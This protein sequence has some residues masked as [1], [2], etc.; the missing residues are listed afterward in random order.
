MAD[1]TQVDPGPAHAEEDHRFSGQPATLGTLSGLEV[2]ERFSF[3]GKQAILRLV[4]HRVVPRRRPRHG[5]GAGASIAAAWG[6][7]I[8]LV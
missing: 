3:L 1:P 8:Y 5:A 7:L 4:L 6:T 2:W